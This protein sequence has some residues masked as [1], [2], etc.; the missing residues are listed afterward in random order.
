MVIKAVRVSRATSRS[1]DYIVKVRARN[2]NN[3]LRR[4]VMHGTTFRQV[5]LAMPCMAI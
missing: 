4:S 3:G 2:L 1:G 5:G